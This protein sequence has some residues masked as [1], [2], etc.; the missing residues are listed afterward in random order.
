MMSNDKKNKYG[1]PM[2]RQMPFE[3]VLIVFC[4][5]VP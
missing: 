5:F 3:F 1:H 4:F 2:S